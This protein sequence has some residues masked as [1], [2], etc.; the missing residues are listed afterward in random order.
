MARMAFPVA[1][2]TGPMTFRVV[3]QKAVGDEV[4]MEVELT[5]L[6]LTQAQYDSLDDES[7]TGYAGII[8]I[9]EEQEH[10]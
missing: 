9:V 10:E 7:R 8:R 4:H 6:R 3:G 2:T 5:R 1:M